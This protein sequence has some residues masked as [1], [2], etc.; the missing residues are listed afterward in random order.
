MPRLDSLDPA[1]YALPPD[2]RAR[3]LSPAL[4]VYLDRVRDNLRS[5]LALTG[6]PARWRP[7]VKTTK[8]PE[9][10]AEVARA[11]VRHFKCATTRELD[12]LLRTLEAEGIPDGDVLVAYPLVGPALGELAR[13]AGQHPDARVSVLCEDAA[14]AA[15]LPEG[16]GRFVDVNPGMHRTGLPLSERETIHA[17]AAAAGTQFRGVHFYD[18][19]LHEDPARRRAAAHAGYDGLLAL[20]HDLLAN[21]LAV[22][23]IIT[24]GT[25]TFRLAMDYPDFAAMSGTVHRVSPGTVV[26]HDQRSEEENPDLDLFPAALLFTRVVSRPS[27]G[28]VTCDAGAKSLSADAGDPAAFVLGRPDLV[29]QPP[30]EE[31]L[32]LRVTGGS[33]PQRGDDLLL[34][35]R[36]VCTTVNLAEEIL[37]VEGG[38]V[39][40]TASVTAR[41]H[42]LF[43]D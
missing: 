40:G 12:Q 19:H 8:T 34:I 17:V 15:A 24:S 5:V 13:V 1:D 22:P 21:G 29:A 2:A 35:P 33:S 41:A 42:P 4:V 7:H 39:V 32:P 18:G 20:V 14:T 3:L 38:R 6:G 27:A 43:P 25:P 10:F 11:G 26:L 23:E 31:H 28:L 30:S 16:I 36:H 9:I 37:L